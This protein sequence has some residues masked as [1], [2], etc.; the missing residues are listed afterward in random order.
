MSGVLT[1]LDSS[2][3]QDL[4]VSEPPLKFR[5]NFWSDDNRGYTALDRLLAESTQWT[6]EMMDMVGMRASLEEEYARQFAVMLKQHPLKGDVGTTRRTTARITQLSVVLVS[7]HSQLASKIR[8]DLEPMLRH[9]LRRQKHIRKSIQNQ[10]LAATK[11]LERDAV[12]H[13]RTYTAYA[14]KSRE[15]SLGK[16]TSVSGTG[17]V[18]AAITS[19]LNVL[20]SDVVKLE[21]DYRSSIHKLNQT[22]D[23]WEYMMVDIC[24]QVQKLEEERLGIM[25]LVWRKLTDT[26]FELT[27]FASRAMEG[28]RKAVEEMDA[29]GD[30]NEIVL[31]RR[32]GSTR[33][34]KVEF[35][36]V[37]AKAHRKV[38]SGRR[39]SEELGG[40][41]LPV[42]VVKKERRE[43]G[44][45]MRRVGS[46]GTLLRN[47][48]WGE[49]GV[50]GRAESASALHRNGTALSNRDT[51]SSLAHD[52][53]NN[54]SRDSV[55]LATA[56]KNAAAGS[57]VPTE[58]SSPRRESVPLVTSVFENLAEAGWGDFFKALSTDRDRFAKPSAFTSM[59]N[60]KVSEEERERSMTFPRDNP[61]TGPDL[62]EQN[63]RS[64]TLQ[65]EYEP[66]A[67][68][69]P[70]ASL[71]VPVAPPRSSSRY[72]IDDPPDCTTPQKPSIDANRRSLP[73]VSTSMSHL[74]PETDDQKKRPG[75]APLEVLQVAMDPVQQSSHDETQTVP[76]ASEAPEI[77]ATSPHPETNTIEKDLPQPTVLPPLPA[78]QLTSH[79]L[80]LDSMSRWTRRLCTLDHATGVLAI[81]SESGEIKCRMNLKGC[82]LGAALNGGFTIVSD[83]GA[84]VVLR[85]GD[86]EVELMWLDA[87]EGWAV[88]T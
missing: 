74:T 29:I 13:E 37:G 88:E 81:Q 83:E 50:L 85:G 45:G 43:S 57:S 79:L 41:L 11:L 68:F 52:N 12:Q 60:T 69:S 87:I 9:F 65:R 71:E 39:F 63:L 6:K 75:S 38:V 46:L 64:Q 70:G 58:E 51:S 10:Y 77:E 23:A 82:R 55:S 2:E 73:V 3:S 20:E 8:E 42:E 66:T 62:E 16:E 59:T 4:A 32:T 78:K 67:S 47:S 14:Q 44:G 33:P 17:T 28:M 25:K 15:L 7:S 1:D 26:Q 35:M 22:Q 86:E 24:D 54:A 61:R 49:G 31:T 56:T 72:E 76:P 80:Q 18:A 36:G 30:C 34:E 53:P 27:S 5:D 21:R 40:L 48:L 19:K 84:R